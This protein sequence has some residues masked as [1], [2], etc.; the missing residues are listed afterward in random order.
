MS[1][2]AVTGLV[3]G[4]FF[5]FCGVSFGMYGDISKWPYL[6]WRKNWDIY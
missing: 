1:F 2:A 5:W 4:V 6:K 3:V